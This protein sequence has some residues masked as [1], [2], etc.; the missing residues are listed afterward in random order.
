MI[1]KRVYTNFT[2]RLPLTHKSTL[3][4]EMYTEDLSIDEE[5]HTANTYTLIQI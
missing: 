3:Y 1:D 5:S 2:L 4:K